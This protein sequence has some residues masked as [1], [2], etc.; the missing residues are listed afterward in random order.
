MPIF[1]KNFIFDTYNGKDIETVLGTDEKCITKR[2]TYPENFKNE[3]IKEIGN[4]LDT[5]KK[6]I[7]VL[8]KNGDKIKFNYR[9]GEVIRKARRK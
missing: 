1:P 6:E 2:L 7:E 4:N 9:T 8:Y 5:D 3:G